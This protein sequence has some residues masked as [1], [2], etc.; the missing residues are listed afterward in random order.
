[1]KIM[2]KKIITVHK[3]NISIKINGTPRLTITYSY[4]V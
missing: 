4:Q 1:M 2:K 3:L